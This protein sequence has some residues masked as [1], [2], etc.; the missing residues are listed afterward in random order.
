M[1]IRPDAVVFSFLVVSLGHALL[2]VETNA[3]KPTLPA[4]SDAMAATV[5]AQNA[6]SLW[7]QTSNS[8]A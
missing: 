4:L 8:L 6:F 3:L 2:L 1:S 7:L 5:S